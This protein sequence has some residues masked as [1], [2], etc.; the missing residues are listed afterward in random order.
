LNV[1]KIFAVTTGVCDSELNCLPDRVGLCDDDN[2]LCLVE[3]GD[4]LLCERTSLR[5]EVE[6][7]AVIETVKHEI[8][9]YLGHFTAAV[10]DYCGRRPQTHTAV[11]RRW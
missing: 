3:S 7:K 10:R 8:G 1:M 4:F 6:D 5:R 9:Y 2:H 11:R